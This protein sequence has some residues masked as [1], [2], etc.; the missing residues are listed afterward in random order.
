MS[1]QCDKNTFRYKSKVCRIFPSFGAF[2]RRYASWRARPWR[3]L[4]FVRTIP[5]LC[6]IFTVSEIMFTIWRFTVLKYGKIRVAFDRCSIFYTTSCQ[7]RPKIYGH[8]AVKNINCRILGLNGNPAS[9]APFATVAFCSNTDIL[10]QC[11]RIADWAIFHVCRIFSNLVAF[12]LRFF[13]VLWNLSHFE[14][15][16]IFQVNDRLATFLFSL[17][18]HPKVVYVV[19]K[20]VHFRS[21]WCI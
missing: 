12:F 8:S 7:M 16:I 2:L 19:L 13:T 10:R 11:D 4:Y 5:I 9:N 3:H 20:M 18:F 21:K 6:R 15:D 1:R 17:P 14:R